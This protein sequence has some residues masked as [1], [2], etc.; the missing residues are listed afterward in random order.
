MT[1]LILAVVVVL[2]GTGCRILPPPNGT[3]VEATGQ[4]WLRAA[5]PANPNHWPSLALAATYPYWRDHDDRLSVHLA[6]NK[7][8]AGPSGDDYGD[9]L[10]VTLAALPILPAIYEAWVVGDRQSTLRWI[11]VVAETSLA[12]LVLTEGLKDLVRRERPDNNSGIGG[13]DRPSTRSFPSGH[14]MGAMTGAALFGRYLREQDPWFTFAELALYGGVGY[15]AI[16]RLEHDKHWPTDVVMS[17]ALAH[18]VANTVWDAHYGR[19]GKPGLFDRLP[20]PIPV[21]MGDGIGVMF[22]VEF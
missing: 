21:P 17:A 3:G 6:R 1:R 18:Y 20:R 13:R 16:T 14:V 5:T 7:K 12:N 2:G 15:V 19:D 11:E 8:Y 4:A 22:G 9:R 10:T